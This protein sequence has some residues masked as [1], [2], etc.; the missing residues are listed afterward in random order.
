MTSD[1]GA[2]FILEHSE[3][4]EAASKDEC[5]TGYLDSVENALQ[6][7]RAYERDTNTKYVC[8]KCPRTFG[9]RG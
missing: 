5:I 4:R 8:L 7:V 2:D 1:V 6:L 9:K 3:F